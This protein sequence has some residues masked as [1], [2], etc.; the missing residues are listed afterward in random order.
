MSGKRS[1]QARYAWKMAQGR[2][3]RV[4]LPEGGSMSEWA[5]ILNAAESEIRQID[6]LP[7]VPVDERWQAV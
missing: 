3:Y 2:G 1:K 6:G 7:P 4:S 5:R